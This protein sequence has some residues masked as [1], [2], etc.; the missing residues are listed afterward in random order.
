MEDVILAPII[1]E[2]SMLLVK[3][4]KYTFKV[5]KT[6]DKVK[7]KKAIKDKFGVD[8]VKV[9]TITVK[10]K[11]KRV[12]KNEFTESSYK[13]AIVKVKDGQKIDLFEIGGSK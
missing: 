12:Q 10:A 2:R 6:S 13:K 3:T 4:G 8:V 5:T 1:T 9:S 11:K 7:I